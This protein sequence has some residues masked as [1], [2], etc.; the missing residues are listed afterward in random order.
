MY[1][2]KVLENRHFFQS[3]LFTLMP[4][5]CNHLKRKLLL[6]FTSIFAAAI[7]FAGCS[8]DT[9]TS[10]EP[11]AEETTGEV[12]EAP[13]SATDEG[14]NTEG[15]DAVAEG[16]EAKTVDLVLT[17]SNW[18]FD[19]EV[20]EVPVGATVQVSII[21]DSGYHTAKINGYNVEVKPNETISFVAEEAGEFEIACSTM[22]GAGH[23]DMTA[24][25]VVV[26]Q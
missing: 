26:D 25:L 19:Q 7:L 13:E 4:Y 5:S 1:S 15:T 17:A 12:S 22:C 3:D 24:K 21:N 18:E 9:D 16:T 2:T 14:N 10:Q 6:L 11:A 23:A 8:S 20:Y